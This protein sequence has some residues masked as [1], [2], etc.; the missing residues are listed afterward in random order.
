MVLKAKAAP[1]YIALEKRNQKPPAERGLNEK[2][3]RPSKGRTGEETRPSHSLFVFY[4]ENRRI[5]KGE[6]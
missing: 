2:N 4:L 5:W 6:S 1:G 3:Q